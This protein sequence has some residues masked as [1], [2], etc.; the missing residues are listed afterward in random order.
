[1]VGK[2]ISH[3][4]ILEKL[5]EGGMG[6]VYKAEDLK[7]NRIVALKFL[8]ATASPSPEDLARFQREAKLIA[9]LN[10]PNIEIIH[11]FD[12]AEGRKFLILEYIPGGTLK[13][14]IRARKPD[15]KQIPPDQVLEYGAQIASALGC[16]H[17]QNIIHRDV[18]SENVMLTDEGIKLTDFGLARFK[19]TTHLT[20]TGTTVGTLAYMSP[21]QLRGEEAD[22][23]SDIFS[24]GVVLYEM[25]T[26]HLPFQGDHEAAIIYSITNEE[27]PP[28]RTFRKNLPENLQRVINLCLEKDASRRYQ[29]ADEVASDLKR[30]DAVAPK[31]AA[32]QSSL[33]WIALGTLILAGLIYLF[34]PAPVSSHG[35]TIAV[36]PFTNMSGNPEDEY[37]SDGI[38]EDVLTQLFKIADFTVISRTSVMQYKGTRK[39][40][41]DIGKELNAGFILEGSVRRAGDQVRIAAQLIDAGT[42]QQ[43]WAETYDREFKQV[44][45]IQGDIAQE[46]GASLHVNLSAKDKERLAGN[47]TSNPAVYNLVLQGRFLLD[48]RDSADVAKALDI[49]K[50]ALLIDSTDARAWAALAGAYHFQAA[51]GLAPGEGFS[52]AKKAAEKAVFFDNNLAEAHRMIGIVKADYEWDWTGAESEFRKALDLEEGNA[53]IIRDLGVLAKR[54]GKLDESVSLAR[55]T[56]ALDPARAANFGFLALALQSAGRFDESVLANK[57][58]LELNPQYP[59]VHI[60]LG[61]L[62][63]L[64]GEFDVAISEAQKE[65]TPD[66]RLLI[67]AMSFF[68]ANRAREADST[69]KELIRGFGDDDAFQIAEIYAYRGDNQN[70]F[71]WLDKAYARRDP[72]LAELR[73]DPFFSKLRGDTRFSGFLRKM[74][75]EG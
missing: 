4:T 40:I 63:V 45:A 57:K 22:H 17:K 58:A 20:R 14:M 33:P 3:F 31:R 73:S 15:D 67:L 39:S 42:D 62:A 65:T 12:E 11:D 32:R 18:K 43:I 46:I 37:F 71:T 13:S 44:F 34:I 68:G 5:G 9:T 30:K 52:W 72:G 75:L 48:R 56:I 7:L 1:M 64:Q 21:E 70:A 19:G 35:K 69:L 49:F 38:M 16:A 66:G 47:K 51:G 2:T 23:R 74:G 54:L 59:F 28:A 55:R 29:S 6:V 26:L 41:R 61:S 10:H 36:L 25:A 27:P 60:A 24:L 50:Q 8:P 53:D